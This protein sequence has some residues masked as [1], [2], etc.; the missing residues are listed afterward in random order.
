MLAIVGGSK[1]ST[2]LSVLKNLV[3]RVDGLI[4][5]GGILATFLAA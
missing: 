5:G 2:K 4:L 1:V 3:N